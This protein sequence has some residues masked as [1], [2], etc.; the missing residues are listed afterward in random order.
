MLI[1]VLEGAIIDLGCYYRSILS[2]GAILSL[3]TISPLEFILISFISISL[4]SLAFL[5]CSPS[6]YVSIIRYD[7]YKVKSFLGLFSRFF[8][9]SR[10]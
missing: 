10:G 9:K 2:D 7:E 5:I 1:F 6:C 8:V 4:L 3:T